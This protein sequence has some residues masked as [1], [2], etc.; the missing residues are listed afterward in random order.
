VVIPGIPSMGSNNRLGFLDIRLAY[1]VGETVATAIETP[2][3]RNNRV[4][5][6]LAT[7]LVM[8]VVHNASQPFLQYI[9]LPQIG[10]ALIIGATLFLLA[11]NWKSLNKESLGPKVIWIPLAVIAGSGVVRILAQPDL[12]TIAGALFMASMFGLYVISRQYGEKA[13]ALFMN[14]VIVLATSIIIVG[15]FNGGGGVEF[16]V[17]YATALADIIVPGTGIPIWKKISWREVY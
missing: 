7:G 14:D 16:N 10:M 13:L 3:R 17:Y 4:A 6:V 8:L 9:F 15:V 12:H 2:F 1:S 5:W 11:D